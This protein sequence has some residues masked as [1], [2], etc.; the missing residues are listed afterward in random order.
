MMKSM[1]YKKRSVLEQLSVQFNLNQIACFNMYCIIVT[2]FIEGHKFI[3][4]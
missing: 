4:F 1:T 2:M 3:S